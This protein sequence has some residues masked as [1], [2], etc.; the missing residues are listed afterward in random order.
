ML[1]TGKLFLAHG[2]IASRAAKT[3]DLPAPRANLQQK[4][5]TTAEKGLGE[6]LLTF[7]PCRKAI[8]MGNAG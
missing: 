2:Q 4:M 8:Q 3:F 5:R 6:L 7:L 1:A